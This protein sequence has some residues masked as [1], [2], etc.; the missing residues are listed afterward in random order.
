[1]AEHAGEMRERLVDVVRRFESSDLERVPDVLEP[2]DDLVAER[3]E[4]SGDRSP[5]VLDQADRDERADDGCG[6][7]P[8]RERDRDADGG[9]PGDDDRFLPEEVAEGVPED[10]DAGRSQFD[11]AD[12]RFQGTHRDPL[13]HVAVLIDHAGE[14]V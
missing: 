3:L 10:A 14:H 5:M 2:G 4:E 11:D 7:G 9:D 8:E 12:E 1:M 6:L 13:D